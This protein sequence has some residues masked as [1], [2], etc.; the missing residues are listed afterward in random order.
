MLERVNFDYENEVEVFMD[1]DFL[2]FL[3]ISE[4]EI[5]KFINFLEEV[6][7]VMEIVFYIMI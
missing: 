4:G 6:F 1:M 5:E 2:E 3:I 7:Y